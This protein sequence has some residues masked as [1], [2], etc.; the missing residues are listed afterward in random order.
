MQQLNELILNITVLGCGDIKHDQNHRHYD[1]VVNR[2]T[3]KIINKN[4][5]IVNVYNGI[6]IMTIKIYN[7][8]ITIKEMSEFMSHFHIDGVG[9]LI[10][11]QPYTHQ[12]NMKLNKLY[13]TDDYVKN[14]EYEDLCLC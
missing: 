14:C 1:F 5:Y 3:F 11:Q 8:T 10:E 13:T 4:N 2:K 12:Y 7:N 6:R 9:Y